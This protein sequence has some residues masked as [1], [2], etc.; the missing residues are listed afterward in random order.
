MPKIPNRSEDLA[1]PRARQ[2]RNRGYEISK[3]EARA[4]TMPEPN[5]TWCEV[6]KGLWVAAQSSGQADFYQDTD[7]WMLYM[8][9]DQVT[10]LYEQSRRSPEFLKSIYSALGGLMFTEA[11]RRKVHVELAAPSDDEDDAALIALADYKEALG[12]AE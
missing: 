9:C 5:E 8:T 2:G 1:R 12:I 11:D 4:V 3:G 7:W 6:A 10:Y